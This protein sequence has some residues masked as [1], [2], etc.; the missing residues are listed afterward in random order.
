MD[1]RRGPFSFGVTFVAFVALNV[2][3]D[4]GTGVVFTNGAN[5]VAGDTVT[6]PGSFFGWATHPVAR[7]QPTAMSRASSVIIFIGGSPF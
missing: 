3:F 2:A 5:V 1:T 6:F 4:P 7:T